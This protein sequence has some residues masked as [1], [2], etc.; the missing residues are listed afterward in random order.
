MLIYAV[1]VL[2]SYGRSAG[3]S[4]QVAVPAAPTLEPPAHIEPKLSPEAVELRWDAVVGPRFEITG[5]RYSYRLYRRELPSGRDVVAGEVPLGGPSPA[6]TDRSFE[7]EKTYEYRVTVVTLIRPENGTEQQVEGGDS[8]PAPIVTHDIF[9]PAEPSGLQ[10]VSSSANQ[11]PFI[12]LV[13]AANQ[14]R[15]LAGYNVFR[16]EPGGP[17]LKLNSELIKQPAFRDTSISPGHE[18]FYSVSAVDVRG[19]ESHR[20]QEAHEVLPAP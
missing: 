11:K 7:W 20:S 16:H 18:Y 2:N 17:E 8:P 19:N 15:D 12:D 5:L 4:N 1:N 9:P 13:W 6:F 10:A 3:L 14:E